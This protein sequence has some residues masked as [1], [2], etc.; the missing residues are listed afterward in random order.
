MTT[1]VIELIANLKHHPDNTVIT[2]KDVDDQEFAIIDF[3]L[4]AR[5]LTILIGTKEE[6]EESSAA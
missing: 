3:T 4:G 2:I 6:D 5:G 1:T